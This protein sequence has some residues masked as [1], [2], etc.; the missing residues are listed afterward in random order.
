MGG[1][2]LRRLK[3]N[4]DTLLAHLLCVVVGLVGSPSS[5]PISRSTPGH[6][7]SEGM[8]MDA[9]ASLTATPGAAAAGKGRKAAVPGP[10]VATSTR[11]GAANN[12]R[13]IPKGDRRGGMYAHCKRDCYAVLLPVRGVHLHPTRNLCNCV[14]PADTSPIVRM[15]GFPGCGRRRG[16]NHWRTAL[17]SYNAL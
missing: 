2:T 3:I 1:P 12:S 11:D 15:H 14:P 7:T 4:Q 13:D 10:T 6:R 16:W 17:E 8:D 5:T 9:T